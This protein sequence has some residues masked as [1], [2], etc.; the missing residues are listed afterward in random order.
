MC[1]KFTLGKQRS[2]INQLLQL[3]AVIEHSATYNYSIATTYKIREV[4]RITL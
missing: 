2:R 1:L 3:T 4:V